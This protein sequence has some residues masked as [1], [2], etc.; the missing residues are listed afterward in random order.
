MC[1][2]SCTKIAVSPMKWGKVEKGDTLRL[3]E[4]GTTLFLDATVRSLLNEKNDLTIYITLVNEKIDWKATACALL[5]P[6][7]NPFRTLLSKHI[8]LR[9]SRK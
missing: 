6:I 5:N 3:R 7:L 2:R 9:A 1:E 8:R 4:I